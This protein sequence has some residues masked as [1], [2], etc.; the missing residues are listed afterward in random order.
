MNTLPPASY[1]QQLNA[2]LKWQ[3]RQMQELESKIGQLQKEIETLKQQRTM[4]VEKIE[5]KFDQL[6]I[7]K[8]DGTLH[9]GVSPDVGKTIEDFSVDGA[10]VTDDAGQQEARDRIRARLDDYLSGE[11]DGLIRGLERQYG[12]DLGDDYRGFIV[13]DIRTQLDRRIE[14]YWNAV[15]EPVGSERPGDKEDTIVD[16]LLTDIRTA[17]ERHIRQK[18][19]K[20]G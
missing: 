11:G 3:S 20:G 13:Q 16:K 19:D 17:I 12:V 18:S 2:Y 15:Q 7:E 1:F 4:T 6:K 10:D 9:I 14:H 5:Y 8:L